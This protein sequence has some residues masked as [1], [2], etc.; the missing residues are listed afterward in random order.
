MRTFGT[1][2][3]ERGACVAGRGRPR[4]VAVGRGRSRSVGSDGAATRRAPQNTE[5]KPDSDPRARGL[6]PRALVLPRR[7]RQAPPRQRP[8]RARLDPRPPRRRSRR[9][10]PRSVD[11]ERLLVHSLF[12]VA[13]AGVGASTRHTRRD[14]APRRSRPPPPSR[15]LARS[16]A[17]RP[18]TATAPR[19]DVARGSELREGREGRR[20]EVCPGR[21]RRPLTLAARSAVQRTSVHSGAPPCVRQNLLSPENA[22]CTTSLLPSSG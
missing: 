11:G 16:L 9:P 3:R 20:R 21:R 6:P 8:P 22:M 2:R 10:N 14:N 4:S 13:R 19:A 7:N 18:P 12:D 5:R 15:A 17:R 1:G